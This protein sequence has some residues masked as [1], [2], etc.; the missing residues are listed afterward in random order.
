[1]YRGKT[2]S[3]DD[4]MYKTASSELLDIEKPKLWMRHEALMQEN[5]YSSNIFKIEAYTIIQSNSA[6]STR[7]YQKCRSHSWDVQHTIHDCT[8]R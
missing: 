2:K 7:R 4:K 3:E 1:M 5:N 6:K 8:R